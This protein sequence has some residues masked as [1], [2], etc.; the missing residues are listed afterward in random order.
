MV[1]CFCLLITRNASSKVNKLSRTNTLIHHQSSQNSRTISSS[2][3]DPYCVLCAKAKTRLIAKE[4]YPISAPGFNP[5]FDCLSRR[6]CV[7]GGNFHHPFLSSG[8]TRDILFCFTYCLPTWN[9]LEK[10]GG[11]EPRIERNSYARNCWM[12]LYPGG[13]SLSTSS[14]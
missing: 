13:L 12:I 4:S 5:P 11:W 2:V 10:I 1:M 3:Q 8:K 14:G 6:D 7:I 9:I